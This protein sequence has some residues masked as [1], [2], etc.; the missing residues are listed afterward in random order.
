MQRNAFGF[1]RRRRTLNEDTYPSVQVI[2]NDLFN[3][4]TTSIRK[5]AFLELVD[6]SA[7]EKQ[8]AAANVIEHLTREPDGSTR[9]WCISALTQL[10]MAKANDA[11][12]RHLSSL[13]KSEWARYW[14]AIALA[15]LHQPDF[16]KHLQQATADPSEMVKAVCFR[17]LLENNIESEKNFAFLV[18]L[19]RDPREVGDRW[20][21]FKAL[22]RNAGNSSLSQAV[23]KRFLPILEEHL[24]DNS[25]P[26][27]V[28]R[29]AALALG[30][31]THEW[32]E[33]IA[34]LHRALHV[35]R[36]DMVKLACVEA[37]AAIGKPEV[38]E[39]LT[40]AL[41]DRSVDVRSRAADALKEILGSTA[42][43]KYLIDEFVLK[44]DQVQPEYVEALHYIDSTA[45]LKVLSTYLGTADRK[46]DA[47][48]RN[49][50]ALLGRDEIAFTQHDQRTEVAKRYQESL[51]EVDKQISEPIKGL[52][53]QIS[54]NSTIGMFMQVAIFIAGIV[55]LLYS[56]SSR[57][58][59]TSTTGTEQAIGIGG[60]IVGLFLMLVVF[61]RGPI[62]NIRR[63]VTNLVQVYVVFLGYLRQLN[64]IDA[65]FSQQL[66]DSAELDFKEVEN[67]INQ[68]QSSVEQ[69]LGE[70]ATHLEHD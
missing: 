50:V 6:L 48:I 12:I 56:L 37:L 36:S 67:S 20:A 46:T 62:N 32:R 45:A 4:Y 25:E 29:Q 68:I 33:A 39:T 18:N 13:E 27:K 15:K 21:A 69:T 14:S 30:D 65:V 52:I 11:A 58:F 41:R 61:Y 47:R 2:L 9:G 44:Q 51:A 8:Q 66:L 63:N 16:D 10:D 31:M 55:L 43:I 64:Q 22:R 57:V 54:F 34:V 49:L 19:A 40:T 60:A 24:V 3:G 23:E 17:L 1:L 59:S 7:S 42:A 5:K 28:Q 35:N 53:H 70:M 26:Q 38:K